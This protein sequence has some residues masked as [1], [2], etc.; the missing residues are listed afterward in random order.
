MKKITSLATTASAVFLASAAIARPDGAQNFYVTAD[1]GAVFQQNATFTEQGFGQNVT[2]NPGAR[3]DLALGYNLS[4]TLGLEFE[5]GF[6]WN[7]VDSLHGV[8]VDSWGESLDLYSVPLMFNVVYRFQT[9]TKWT[10][11]VGAGIGA[12]I[13]TFDGSTRYFNASDTTVAFAYQAEVGLKYELS[14]RAFVDLGYK[15]F[16]STDQDFSLGLPYNHT[17]NVSFGSIYVHGIFA[18]FT[19]NF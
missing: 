5:P 2:F 18:S 13:V 14:D 16:G 12:D 11:Y 10:P 6:M 17:D 4:D 19:L 7:S 9:D 8:S 3:I 1:A 15:F